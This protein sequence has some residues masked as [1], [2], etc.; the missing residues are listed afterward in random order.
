MFAVSEAD[1][2]AIRAVFHQ[3]ELRPLFPGLDAG[4]GA[5]TIAGWEPRS[6]RRLCPATA[7]RQRVASET[8]HAENTAIENLTKPRTP[9]GKGTRDL[10]LPQAA[11]SV[12]DC[13]TLLW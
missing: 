6:G 7:S 10:G 5:R 3:R 9:R 11:F 2:A 4:D 12:S 13:M 8:C 1:A